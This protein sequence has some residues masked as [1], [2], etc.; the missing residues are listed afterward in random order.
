VYVN[1]FD[2]RSLAWTMAAL[3][4]PYLK[5]DDLTW[6]WVEIGAGD[7]ESA[8]VT[9]VGCCVRNDVRFP[10]NVATTLRGWL[11]GYS[12]TAVSAAFEPYAE[13][14]AMAACVGEVDSGY[15][16][17]HVGAE[18][19]GKHPRQD[20]PGVGIVRGRWAVPGRPHRTTVPAQRSH[21]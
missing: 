8:L 15:E 4:A 6:L 14:I 13:R 21:A 12:G 5:P 7:L 11:D 10:P 3:A 1:R 19:L 20:L 16:G 18:S 2:Q 9:L 17:L